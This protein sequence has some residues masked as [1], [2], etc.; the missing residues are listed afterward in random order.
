MESE[1]SILAAYTLPVFAFTC[2]EVPLRIAGPA[3]L[4]VGVL[5]QAVL[6]HGPSGQ[7]LPLSLITA[8][9]GVMT[10]WIFGQEPSAQQGRTA[11]NVHID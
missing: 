7:A 10:I 3:S 11:L 6:V 9:L 8:L 1:I 4:L 5:A 2:S